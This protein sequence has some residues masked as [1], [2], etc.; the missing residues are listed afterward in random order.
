MAAQLGR[1]MLLKLD[2]TGSAAY[3]AIGGVVTRSLKMD[4]EE[5]DVTTSDSTNQWRELLANAGIKSMEVS[6]NGIFIDDTYVNMVNVLKI[7]GTI[8]N[9]QITHPSIGTYTAAFFIKAYEIN[10]D[11]NGP[12]EFSI[13]LASA[14]EVTFSA[15]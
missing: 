3:F 11:K 9:W 8:R 1:T 6:F 2:T 7:A 4:E 14:G 10:G 13:T 15:L 5:V 12:V